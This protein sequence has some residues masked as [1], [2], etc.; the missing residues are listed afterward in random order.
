[1]IPR[2]TLMHRK[3][4]ENIRFAKNIIKDGL[5]TNL[6]GQLRELTK[7]FQLSLPSGDLLYLRGGWYV[8]HTGL[9]HLAA[10]RRCRGINFVLRYMTPSFLTVTKRWRNLRPS[11]LLSIEMCWRTKY[12]RGVFERFI[13]SELDT[14]EFAFCRSAL[15]IK[16]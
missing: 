6:L 9:I 5:S 8:T 7:N 4:A 11:F 15:N 3:I 13:N 16:A 12:S 1:V 14:I 10:R 2:K